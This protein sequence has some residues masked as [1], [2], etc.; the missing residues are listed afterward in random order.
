M[1]FK[2]SRGIIRLHALNEFVTEWWICDWMFKNTVFR[3]SLCD[4]KNRAF[5]FVWK[6]LKFE[7]KIFL[8]SFKGW[9][10]IT[11]YFTIGNWIYLDC[12]NYPL[13]FRIHS[14][15]SLI[16]HSQSLFLVSYAYLLYSVVGWSNR[17]CFVVASNC[18]VCYYCFLLVPLWRFVSSCILFAFCSGGLNGCAAG[19]HFL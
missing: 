13:T 5:Y 4:Q 16:Q 19:L 8:P 3:L 6:C 14:Y 9:L 1:K 2:V 10:I 17:Y 12:N 11:H 15:H 7:I 18:L